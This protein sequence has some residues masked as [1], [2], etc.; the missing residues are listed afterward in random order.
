MKSQCYTCD[1][2]GFIPEP[3]TGFLGLF[4]RKQWCPFCKGT[5]RGDPPDPPESPLP[6]EMTRRHFSASDETDKAIIELEEAIQDWNPYQA[7]SAGP[8]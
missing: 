4:C 8:R 3:G 1:G 6:T 2:T 5:G 7:N